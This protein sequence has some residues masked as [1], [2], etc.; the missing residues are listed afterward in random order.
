M[1]ESR[2]VG[3]YL[4]CDEIASGGMA[5]VHLGRLMGTA[6]FA[7][8]VAIKRLHPQFARDPDFVSM[9]LDEARLVARIRHPN[10]VPTVDVVAEDGE[11][12]LVMEYVHGESVSRLLRGGPP[13]PI[14]VTVAIMADALHGL[15][16]AHV[17]T[18]ETGEPLSIVHRDVSPQNIVV[19]AEGVARIL[20]FGVAKASQRIQT[21]QDGSVKGKFAYMA[22]EQLRRLPLDART[23]VFA[24]GVVLWELLVGKRLFAGNDPAALVE[25]VLYADIPSPSTVVPAVSASLDRVVAKALARHPEDRFTS[26]E[27][28]AMALEEACAP[29]RQHEVGRWVRERA[30]PELNRKAASVRE[31]ETSDG[32][33]RDG[34]AMATREAVASWIREPRIRDTR[35]ASVA[36]ADVLVTE[37]GISAALPALEEPSRRRR[38]G[39]VVLT[40]SLVAS[41]AVG[42]ALLA[43]PPSKHFG[44]HPL[45]VAANQT[46]SEV[47]GPARIEPRADETPVAPPTPEPAPTVTTKPTS[48]IPPAAARNVPRTPSAPKPLPAA[49]PAKSCD[50]PHY[51]DAQGVKHFKPECL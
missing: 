12:V 1:R 21:T 41:F 45:K 6:G 18:S 3:R 43:A 13:P 15:H 22:P 26:A 35:S 30:A 47:P 4:L 40:A 31:V 11:L 16:A 27:E 20:D 34:G 2:V 29:A 37:T 25:S 19:G 42:A 24:A 38:G 10:V 8:T 36:P 28:M 14:P 32:Q 50:P 9:F 5:A 7:R 44:E 23:D 51:V 33:A 49:S 46:P 17:A 48:P 39:S